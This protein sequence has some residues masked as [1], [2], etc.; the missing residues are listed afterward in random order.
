MGDIVGEITDAHDGDSGQT[1]AGGGQTRAV[2]LTT[3]PVLCDVVRSELARRRQALTVAS[4]VAG[5]SASASASASTVGTLGPGTRLL[6]FGDS[7]TAGFSLGGWSR[8]FA[9]SGVHTQLFL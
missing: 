6:C 8:L 2:R 7:L 4:T 3:Y 1:R 5:T 9:T